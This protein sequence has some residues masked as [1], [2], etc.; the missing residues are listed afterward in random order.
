MLEWRL[1]L[2]AYPETRLG[3]PDDP[4]IDGALFYVDQALDYVE[5]EDE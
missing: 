4:P 3:A 2:E 5:E 1:T